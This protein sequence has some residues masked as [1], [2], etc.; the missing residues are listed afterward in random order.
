M[1]V[2]C[3]SY[4]TTHDSMIKIILLVIII[5]LSALSLITYEI[6]PDGPYDDSY[7]HLKLIGPGIFYSLFLSAFIKGTAKRIIFIYLI[8]VALWIILF[9]LTYASWGMITPISGAVSGLIIGRIISG[10]DD[11]FS[12][13]RDPDLWT[14]ALSATVGLLLFFYVNSN[15][16]YTWG[17]KLM[18]I[19]LCW[20]LAMGILLIRNSS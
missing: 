3:Y 8:F 2:T 17:F 14:G 20:Q 12:L 15:N 18:W 1:G 16:I 5:I 11:N 7:D 6:Y 4:T 19:V 13:K 9:W 10:L